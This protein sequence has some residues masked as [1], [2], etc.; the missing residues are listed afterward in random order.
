MNAKATVG[1]VSG[2]AA[3]RDLANDPR[4]NSLGINV[5]GATI[6]FTDINTSNMTT[7][8]RVAY[9]KTILGVRVGQF[10]QYSGVTSI[11]P[12]VLMLENS[13][14]LGNAVRQM[15]NAPTRREQDCKGC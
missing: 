6:T 5:A 10:V 7:A 3:F 14:M 12:R 11:D 8:W 2:S 9:D 1:F 4:L 15:M 13:G